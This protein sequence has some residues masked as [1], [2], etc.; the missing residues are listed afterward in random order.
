MPGSW[1]SRHWRQDDCLPRASPPS[2]ASGH[3]SSRHNSKRNHGIQQKHDQHDLPSRDDGD[4]DSSIHQITDRSFSRAS[5]HHSRGESHRDPMRFSTQHRQSLSSRTNETSSISSSESRDKWR[6]GQP[7]PMPPPPSSTLRTTRGNNLDSHRTS[8]GRNQGDSYQK[9]RQHLNPKHSGH[10]PKSTGRTRQTCPSN[11]PNPWDKGTM[12]SSLASRSHASNPD[13]KHGN[14]NDLANDKPNVWEKPDSGAS[15]DGGKKSVNDCNTLGNK[16][17]NTWEKR[18]NVLTEG[19]GKRQ[20]DYNTPPEKQT[21]AWVKP[22]ADASNTPAIAKGQSI[23]AKSQGK[24]QNPWTKPD[25]IAPIKLKPPNASFFPS[26]SD[27]TQKKN[28]ASINVSTTSNQQQSTAPLSLPSTSLWGK[29][30]SPSENSGDV[31]AKIESS[32]NVEEFPSLSTAL[33]APHSIQQSQLLVGSSLL[34]ASFNNDQDVKGKGQKKSTNLASFLPPQL[35]GNDTSIKKNKTPSSRAKHSSSSTKTV[36][37][38][39]KN[40]SGIK[41]SVVSS[42]S[43]TPAARGSHALSLHPSITKGMGEPV[44]KKGRQRLTPKKKKLTTLKKRVLEERLRVWKERNENSTA[45]NSEKG[46]DVMPPDTINQECATAPPIRDNGEKVQSSETLLIENFVSPE[47]DDLTDDDEYDEIISNILSLTGR[48]GKVASVFVPRPSLLLG[49]GTLEDDMSNSMAALEPTYV[50][51]AFVR[52]TTTNDAKAGRDILDGITVGGQRIRVSILEL[53]NGDSRERN[54]SDAHSALDDR[55]WKLA[56]LQCMSRR[57]SVFEQECHARC[58]NRNPDMSVEPSSSNTIVLHNILTQDDYEDVDALNESVEDIS[59]LARQ[60][61]KLIGAR[62]STAGFDKGNIYVSY[63]DDKVAEKA[64]QQMNGLVVGGT[65]ISVSTQFKS[66]HFNEQSR[67]VEVIMENVL[68]VN[69]FDDEDCLNESL[70]DISNLVRKYGLIGRVFADTIGEEKGKVHIEYLDGEGAAQNAAEQLNGMV[71]GGLVVSAKVASRDRHVDSSSADKANLADQAPPPIY[72]GD[73]IIPERFAACKR[74]PKIPNSGPRSYAV[75]VND[76]RALPLLIEM[77]GELMRLQER[78]RDD[79]NARARRRLVMGLRE[80]ARGIR[81]HKVKMVV[82]ANNLDEYGAIDAKLQEILDIARAEDVPV[83][84]EFN[85]RKLGKALGKSIKVSVVGIQ[86]AD[87]AQE[88]FKQLRKI[89]G[90]A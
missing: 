21:N 88:Q 26:L 5:Y 73:K 60:Y 56:V 70:G 4:R 48:V 33:N 10:L 71:I 23:T 59:S 46:L 63:T 62:A 66:P 32:S 17:S 41:R 7:I 28:N 42:I 35:S 43:A 1:H 40:T 84:F 89:L 16:Q 53:N 45:N 47:E 50:G 25:S 69:D 30:S 31:Q 81:A 24:L 6:R 85:K 82:M 54:P 18:E 29:R 44:L 51:F 9:E 8:N 78:S 74:V 55:K 57:H 12:Q 3:S 79:K 86:N 68:N 34:A 64:A 39:K 90:V 87:G 76:E 13:G 38:V 67:S 58:E 27:T 14:S 77:L 83:V 19:G 75:K 22:S 11:P 2:G 49:N 52:F 36:T 80:V 72:S 37:A 20:I 65:Q 15:D 61:G